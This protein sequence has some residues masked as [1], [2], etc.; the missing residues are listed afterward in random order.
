MFSIANSR[1]RQ[2]AIALALGTGLFLAAGFIPVAQGIVDSMV[3]P[4]LPGRARVLAWF[5]CLA[6]PVLA[7]AF[8]LSIPR[9]SRPQR[10]ELPL[11]SFPIPIAI[12]LLYGLAD[13]SPGIFSLIGSSEAQVAAVWVI[14]LAPLGEEWLF[15]GWL[16][17]LAHR[18]W[19]GRLATATNPL[20]V[21]VWVTAIAFSLWHLQNWGPEPAMRVLWQ[22]AYTL[23]AGLWL[24]WLRWRSGGLT[25]PIL[26]HI[27]LN[28]ATALA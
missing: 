22:L 21:A 4:F 8:Y 28:A 7:W 15:R 27:S 17:S 16:Y 23:P 14:L 1:E 25:L 5:E 12:G 2:A 20:P 11:W 26:A 3:A 19:R 6:F 10:P 24:G 18:L 9:P 13:P